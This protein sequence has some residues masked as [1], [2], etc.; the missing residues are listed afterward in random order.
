[1]ANLIKGDIA[2]YTGLNLSVRSGTGASGDIELQLNG[3]L[4][5]ESYTLNIDS[6]VNITGKN[7]R[8]AVWGTSTF[9][10][11][12]NCDG[13][14]RKIQVS[15][16]PDT[17]YRGLM[18]DLARQWHTTRDIEEIIDLCRLY[19]INY[20]QLHLTDDA[21]FT[22]T[23][24]AYPL[25]ATQGRSYSLAE[26]NGLESY[27][28][29][30]GVT[31]VP[32]LDVPGH[33][34]AMVAAYPD[35]FGSADKNN[36]I[37][38]AS[39]EVW[40][41]VGTL[42]QELSEVFKATPYIHIGG[43]EVDFS[44]LGSRQDFIDA[45]ATYGVGDVH[46][47]FNY[48]IN[49]VNGYI[50]AEGKNTLVWEGF[51][52]GRSGNAKMDT[53]V[54][55]CPFDNYISAD[56]YANNGHN[57]LNTSWFPLY[58]VPDTYV[59]TEKIY[60]WDKTI[61]GNYN[62][63]SPRAHENVRQYTMSSPQKI[64]GAQTCSWEQNASYEIPSLRSRLCTMSERIWN[65]NAGKT[66][67]DY[68]A[69]FDK[70]DKVLQ[71]I[72]A[73]D[74]PEPITP[75]ASFDVFTDKI[76]VRWNAGGQYPSAYTLYRG[77]SDN[78]ATATPIL[79][80]TQ[81]RSY[82][83]T[84]VSSG[85]TYY[86]WVKAHNTVGT[87]TFGG[88]EQGRAGT[89]DLTHVYEPFN[90]NP[91]SNLSGLNGGEGFNGGWTITQ[92]S[93]TPK[94]LDTGLS[95]PNLQTS[96][97]SLNL[98]MSTASGSLTLE[99]SL[100]GSLNPEGSEVWLS[101]LI[102]SIK[103]GDG[104]CYL[105]LGNA[106][107]G[108]KYF[109]GIDVS[110]RLNAQIGLVEGETNLIVLRI[111]NFDGADNIHLWANPVINGAQPDDS[112]PNCYFSDRVDF[113]TNPIMKIDAQQYG[114]GSYVLDELRVGDS[115]SDVLPQGDGPVDPPPINPP[116]DPID[117]IDPPASSGLQATYYNN[118]NFSG[119]TITR[120]DP[121]IDFQWGGGSPDPRID[122]DTYSARWEGYVESP[123]SG[124]YTFYTTTDDG[125]RLWIN[126]QLLIDQWVDQAPKEYSGNI[127]LTAGQKVTLKMEY[128]ENGGG[129]VAKLLWSGP[130][131]AK[132]IIPEQYLS[133]TN[134]GEDPGPDPDPTPPT[135]PSSGLQATYYNNMNFSG[136][137][138][139]RIDPTID[140][141]WGGGSPDPKIDNDTYSARWEGYVES[142]SSGNYTFYTTTDDGVRLWINDQLL[143]D[144][145]VDQA[146]KEYTGAI[147]MSA[148]QKVSLKMEYYENGGGAVAKL[149]WS[150]PGVGKQIIPEQYLSTTN[151][152][153][154]PNPVDPSNEFIDDR[155]PR[156]AYSG[157]WNQYSENIYYDNTCSVP[158]SQGAFVS[159]TFTGNYIAW[160]GLK[161][162]DLGYAEV[163]LDDVSQGKI[164]CYSASRITSMLFEKGGLPE[165]NHTIKI[166]RTTEKN[167]ASSNYFLVHDYFE[168][169]SGGDYTPPENMVQGLVAT[170]YNNM[171]FTG[172]SLSRIDP[173][174][175]FQWGG[176]LPIRKLEMTPI[177][178]F[179]KDL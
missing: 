5:E 31:I 141:Q 8:A 154:S 14:A 43:D 79:S 115:Y 70:S 49:Q 129:A 145:W 95:Y 133:T 166:V 72:L 13:S 169:R 164:D 98:D 71:A 37:N 42:V 88:S 11:V 111:E 92:N 16:S 47:L 116:V 67:S 82:S 44:G 57:I 102:Q 121:T 99:R 179:G 2:K 90:Y 6:K 41:A 156:T 97:K 54:I 86:Y 96:G 168:V 159:L 27:S 140:F 126:D 105:T 83:D 58:L 46:G 93:G 36:V 161:N 40:A 87:S 175:D 74:L 69:R 155:D 118:M 147:S 56:V 178:L 151:G 81:E 173:V 108:K 123:S 66:F 29:A 55:V 113:G 53:D 119:T 104:H 65:V 77:T 28:Q 144:Q 68:L 78:S 19:K 12:L 34:R 18:V 23:S 124:N 142:P 114:Q 132:Q 38:F 174:I 15:D 110:N 9:L 30:R 39:T 64:I 26:L 73:N 170:Y 20:L 107:V 63:A 177:R 138:I 35:L 22:F 7:Y 80:N 160:H 109:N 17:N 127:S 45:F 21:S 131:V 106:A 125:V 122:N 76:E 153:E 167:P 112:T 171:D 103:N 162:T 91:N 152:N 100:A 10:Q 52:S 163:I 135:T 117:P 61:F 24:K 130:G 1:M 157:S 134:D 32:E 149:L 85:Q 51:D 139:T 143:I 136:T 62:S 176:V 60:Q 150:G 89:L 75:S 3:G 172:S 4:A 94:I 59:P 128:Y 33:A 120:I 101:F 48:F 50:K 148:G 165:G 137:T 84:Q 146:P 158:F 25:L